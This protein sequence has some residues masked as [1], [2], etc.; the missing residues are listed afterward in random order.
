MSKVVY[1]GMDVHQETVVMVGIGAKSSE[2]ELFSLRIPNDRESLRRQLGRLQL[3][4]QLR[5]CYEAGSCGLVLYHWLQAM[6][7]SCCVVAPS[8]IPKKAGDRV[9]T[10]YRDALHLA[11]MY[12]SQA[13]TPIHIVTQA[14]EATRS[15]VRS[16][17]AL[18]RDLQRVQQRLL[19]FL[20]ARGLSYHEGDNWTVK[21]GRYLRGLEFAEPAA[22]VYRQLLLTVEFHGQQ[23]REVDQAL[24]QVA[25]SAEYAG[26]VSR[27]R[28]FRGIDTL[29]AMV[30]ITEIADFQRFAKASS[31]MNYL[32]LTPS[33]HS[34]GQRQQR[35]R[36]TKAGN[37]RARRIVIEAAWHAR[38]KPH[39]SQRLKCCHAQ[40][41]AAVVAISLKAQQRLYRKFCRLGFRKDHNTTVV[42]VARELVGFLWAAMVHDEQ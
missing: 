19:K 18:R 16:R 21:H 14:Q 20:Q 33:E 24:E 28:C 37:E 25:F 35:G 23:L 7:I 17:E 40:A 9:K 38:H 2:G 11:Q 8:L 31:L 10:D 27:L 39:L 42:A 5:C 6:A 26:P 3:R 1:V 15:L 41:Q 36:I 30:L 12:R 32:G 13:L 34:S 29:S 4:Y 22:S